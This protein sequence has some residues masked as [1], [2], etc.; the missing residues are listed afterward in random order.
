MELVKKVEQRNLTINTPQNQSQVVDKVSNMKDTIC[1]REYNCQ[2]KRIT[3][4]YVWESQIDE[5]KVNCF[6]CGKELG[7]KS[8]KIKKVP[9]T[10]SIR[11]PTK[12][13]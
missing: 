6:Q 2:C 1:K 12:N 4:D 9:Q 10:A 3:T 5:H 13:R 7:F 11:T 8:I